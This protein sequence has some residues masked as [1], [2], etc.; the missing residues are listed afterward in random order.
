MRLNDLE[1]VKLAMNWGTEVQ[2]EEAAHA[3][4]LT[5]ERAYQ[6]YKTDL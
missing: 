1:V 3:K 5:Q 6:V 2:A 4:F